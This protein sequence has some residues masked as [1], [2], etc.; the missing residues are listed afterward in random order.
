MDNKRSIG[1]GEERH[2][3]GRGLHKPDLRAHVTHR[4]E[5]GGECHL[6]GPCCSHPC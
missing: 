5:H 3:D 6:W 2:G 4:L 1:H